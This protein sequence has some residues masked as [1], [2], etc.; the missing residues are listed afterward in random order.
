MHAKYALFILFN[1]VFAVCAD[2]S[3]TQT[4]VDG[5]LLDQ[6]LTFTCDVG[7][8]QLR[9]VMDHR[10]D[11]VAGQLDQSI[12]DREGEIQQAVEPTYCDDNN[13][14]SEIVASDNGEEQQAAGQTGDVTDRLGQPHLIKRWGLLSFMVRS[15]K[16]RNADCVSHPDTSSDRIRAELRLLST[17]RLI[18]L[19]LYSICQ[20]E[21]V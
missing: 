9:A 20:T 12:A 10:Y 7:K 5:D 14:M 15:D 19:P 3:T 8:K 17:S 18:G 11:D 1:T 6:S 2:L 13:I 4:S 21:T 16:C